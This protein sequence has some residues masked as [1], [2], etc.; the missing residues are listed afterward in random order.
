L[1]V[2]GRKEEEDE[3]KSEKSRP[4]FSRPFLSRPGETIFLIANKSLIT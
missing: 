3:K 4:I 1:S 2:K